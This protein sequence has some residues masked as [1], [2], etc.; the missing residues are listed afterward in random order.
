MATVKAVLETTNYAVSIEA[1]PHR[2]AADE[3]PARGGLGHGPAPYDLLLGALAACTVITL[4]MYAERKGWHLGEIRAELTH[5]RIDGRSR[6]T[7]QLG[8]EAELSDDQRKRLAEIAEKT[9]V[10][11]TLKQGAD[12][13]TEIVTGPA[14][15]E[16]PAELDERLDEALEESFPASDPPSISPG[17]G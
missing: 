2:L 3:P 17:E 8:F 1:G 6:I 15:G 13:V 9:P 14:H 12:I 10:T 16:T 7:R 4:R 5:A 11:L